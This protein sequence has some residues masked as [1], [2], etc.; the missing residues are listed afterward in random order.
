MQSARRV[1]PVRVRRMPRVRGVRPVSVVRRV[2][3]YSGVFAGFDP[4]TGVGVTA[5]GLG[6]DVE[7]AAF[8]GAVMPAIMSTT[9]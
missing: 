5:N 4:I 9:K 7:G 8:E 1:R 6:L 2:C 3:G